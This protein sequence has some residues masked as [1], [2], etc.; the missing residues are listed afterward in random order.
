MKQYKEMCLINGKMIEC[1]VNIDADYDDMGLDV[2]GLEQDDINALEAK[3]ASGRLSIMN[4][5]VTVSAFG[6]KGQDSLGGCY[7]SSSEDV[8]NIVTEYSMVENATD[9]LSKAVA[10]MFRDLNAIYSK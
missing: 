7:I 2:L 1:T 6:L 4:V 3:I 8:Q 9:E 5:L 10:E